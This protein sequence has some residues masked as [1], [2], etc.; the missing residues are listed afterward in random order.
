SPP[1]NI[2]E[3]PSYAQDN[4]PP[5]TNNNYA[6]RLPQHIQT[7]EKVVVVDPKVHAWGAYDAN[8][9]LIRS[10]LAS[11]GANWCPD[12]HRRCH[13]SV[14]T[15]RVYSLGSASCKSSIYPIPRGGA[16]MPYCMFFNRNLA[17]HGSPASHVVD[18]N[19]SHGCVRLRVND[20]EW[21]RFNFVRVGTKVIIKP[22]G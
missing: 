10:G 12:L 8:G 17:L 6:S 4:N 20:A 1:T 13:T 18:G 11:A 22:Y 19:V 16:P 3:F 2:H 14:G 21:L 5:S 15:F 9:N 7:N